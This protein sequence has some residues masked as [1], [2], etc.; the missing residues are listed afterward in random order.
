MQKSLEKK[1]KPGEKQLERRAEILDRLGV[2]RAENAAVNQR[3]RW[4]HRSNIA[5]ACSIGRKQIHGEGN[6]GTGG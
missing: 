3:E 5:F 2:G 1:K 6:T 4:G